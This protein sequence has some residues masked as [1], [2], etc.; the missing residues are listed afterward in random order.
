MKTLTVPEIDRATDRWVALF[1]VLAAV[2]GIMAEVWPAAALALVIAL[3]LGVVIVAT[4]RELHL[5]DAHS[6]DYCDSDAH[7]ADVVH[8][9]ERLA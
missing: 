8:E 6:E 4:G 1:A 9:Q 5:A 3:A 7:L 2:A